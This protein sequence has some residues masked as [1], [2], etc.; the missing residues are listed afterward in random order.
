M[1]S[2]FNF[3]SSIGQSIFDICTYTVKGSFARLSP[4][5]GKVFIWNV[6][7]KAIDLSVNYPTYKH[8]IEREKRIGP[9]IDIHVKV[10]SFTLSNFVARLSDRDLVELQAKG[11]RH[12]TYDMIP[13]LKYIEASLVFFDYGYTGVFIS[14]DSVE[15]ITDDMV[16]ACIN[17]YFFYTILSEL[18]WSQRKW[19][20]THLQFVLALYFTWRVFN[21]IL[22]SPGPKHIGHYWHYVMSKGRGIGIGQ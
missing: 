2:L 19:I 14:L 16:V 4:L 6:Y 3:V 20:L 8:F 11:L 18:K 7:Q 17:P 10:P 9:S 22:G 5:K 13:Q 15:S 21:L 12:T 1:W